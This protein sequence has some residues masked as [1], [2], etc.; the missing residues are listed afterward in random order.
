MI[1]PADRLSH[2]SEYYFSQKLRD[3]AAMKASGIEVINMGSGSP[4]LPPHPSVIKALNDCSNLDHAHGYQNYQ[5]T[6]AL[7]QAI[8]SFYKECFKVTLNPEG[9]VLPMMGSKE[10]IF[11]ISMA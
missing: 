4:D 3:V 11:H 2:V 1:K 10:A 6:P 9:E 7:R 8:A 5:G